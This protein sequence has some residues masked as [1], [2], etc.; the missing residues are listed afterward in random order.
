MHR[1]SRICRDIF[2]LAQS[3]LPSEAGR[4]RGQ[5]WEDLVFDYLLR[6]GVPVESVPG[7]D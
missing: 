2:L 7:G 4:G 3:E 5:A 1:F 6:H